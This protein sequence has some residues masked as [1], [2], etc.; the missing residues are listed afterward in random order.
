[1]TSVISDVLLPLLS[2][3]ETQSSSKRRRT[4]EKGV[5]RTNTRS[6]LVK[7][8]TTF[9]VGVDKKYGRRTSGHDRL[10]LP[11]LRLLLLPNNDC[12]EEGQKLAMLEEKQSKDQ[13][14]KT[15]LRVKSV[16]AV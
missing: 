7:L 9:C 14:E 3:F 13:E 15:I 11:I 8:Y 4:S 1:M 6:F 12:L 16:I 5:S 2:F 10:S